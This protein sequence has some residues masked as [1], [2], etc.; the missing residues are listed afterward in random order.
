M[1]APQRVDLTLDLASSAEKVTVTGAVEVLETDSS[2]RGEVVASREIVNETPRKTQS[3][4][5]F[6]GWD[7][8]RY[9][10]G[11][12]RRGGGGN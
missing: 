11:Q 5:R 7:G 12:E 6:V 2:D 9:S 10:L 3:R 4:T 8:G 1:N